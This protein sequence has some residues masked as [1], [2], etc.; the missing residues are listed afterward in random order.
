MPKNKKT[1][2]GFLALALAVTFFGLTSFAFAQAEQALTSDIAITK[3]WAINSSP[4]P[5][6]LVDFT[7]FYSNLGTSENVTNVVLTVNYDS[8][9]LYDISLGDPTDCQD[10][11]SAVVCHFNTVT[12]GEENTVG[13]TARVIP[14]AIPDTE[15]PFTAT[16]KG[17]ATEDKI[18]NDVQYL[19][20][21][22]TSLENGGKLTGAGM[23]ANLEG[24]TLDKA[25]TKG[26][27]TVF[28]V[29]K[30]PNWK[31]DSL[32]TLG[33][34]FMIRAKEALAWTLNITDAGFGN[35]A[36]RTN[37]LKVLTVVN[38]LFILGLLAIAAMWMFSLFIPRRYLRQVIVLY[39]LTVISV[40]FALPINQ[41]LIEGSNLL[42]RTFIGS[43][44]ISDIVDLPNYNDPNSISYE[45]ETGDLK[46]AASQNVSVNLGNSDSQAA[47]DVVVGQLQST[48]NTPTL[49]GTLT[50]D[51]K[52]QA[53]QLSDAGNDPLLHLNA[54]QSVNL[55]TENTFNPN[56]EHRIFAFILLLLTGLAYFGMAL[57]FILRI[58]ILWALMIV[59]PILFLLA[60]F[61]STRGYFYNWL[62]IYARWLLIGPLMALGIA[63]VVG[64]WQAVGL[65][66]LS[67]YSGLG[68][69]GQLTNL[70]FFLPGSTVANNLSTTPEMMQYLVFLTMLYLPLFF[71]FMLTRQKTLGG[72][73]VNVEK[74]VT[75]R[76]ASATPAAEAATTPKALTPVEQARELGT[77]IRGFLGTGIARAGTPMPAN[78]RATESRGPTLMPGTSTLPEQLAFTPMHEMLNLA[79]GGGAEGIRNAH[80]KAIE[81]LASADQMP[82]SP[83]RQN[84]LAV[85]HEI[86]DRASKGDLE[87]LRVL[88]EIHEKE[89]TQ[90]ST[91]TE[92][93]IPTTTGGVIEVKT[94]VTMAPETS[95]KTNETNVKRIETALSKK[96]EDETRETT[97]TK[98]L[99]EEDKEA[100][101][102]DMNAKKKKR[103][104]DHQ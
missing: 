104:Q 37:Y 83:E 24:G 68:Q 101:E 62:T 54:N 88:D 38:G 95:A 25:A 34:K 1:R 72:A 14:T 50:T 79:A 100:K 35:P 99:E 17:D 36:I 45:N 71:A 5:N 20:V 73:L 32:S 47:K 15:I 91:S 67:S 96:M 98:K 61:R 2:S 76:T 49:T 84:A 64:I 42:Q 23:S 82:D 78:L 13:F 81:K 46:Q 93:P 63:I 77:G 87:A 92:R 65:P 80:G 53:I 103:K 16:I 19:S 102:E 90:V 59:S 85:R 39:G 60:V 56:D 31:T 44:N 40:N 70:G 21:I 6:G 10:T 7:V 26:S 22:V 58:V 74:S 57:V 66:I 86:E 33:L 97:E 27:V 4:A 3:L 28:D 75:E 41:I 8:K 55:V 30:D 89:S 43:T 52:V 94:P 18:Q 11:K 48:L 29:S 9:N 12:P 69:F 51:G